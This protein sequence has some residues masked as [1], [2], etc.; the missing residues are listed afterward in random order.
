M[1]KELSKKITAFKELLKI[2]EEGSFDLYETYG[3]NIY[4]TRA[5]PVECFKHLWEL[6]RSKKMTRQEALDKTLM[7]L[8][9][10]DLPKTVQGMEKE[11]KVIHLTLLA[12]ANPNTFDSYSNGRVSAFQS[13]WNSR[14]VY[15][16]L[17][18][19]QDNRFE[20]PNELQE[21]YENFY[22]EPLYCS[23]SDEEYALNKQKNQNRDDLIYALFQ[24]NMFP[25]NLNVFKE[26]EPV[27]LKKDPQFFEKKKQEMQKCLV[28]AKT[29]TQIYTAF[30]GKRKEKN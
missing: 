20:P 3:D 30:I 11:K 18:L 2:A 23:F 4:G 29:P 13:F 21:F 5:W 22:W 24:R 19:V 8:T 26:L 7:R 16:L 1:A 25:T 10:G 15:G 28:R 9:R 6:K 17:E 12:G 14:K 27:V